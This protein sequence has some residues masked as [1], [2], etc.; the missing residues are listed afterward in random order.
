MILINRQT[1]Q[2]MWLCTHMHPNADDNFILVL[3][4][5][6]LFVCLLVFNSVSAPACPQDP[7]LPLCKDDT[8][9]VVG[10]IKK[11]SLHVPILVPATL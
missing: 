11:R 3:S 7:S 1:F 6:C 2:G 9:S 5:Q 8:Q 4:S 10:N